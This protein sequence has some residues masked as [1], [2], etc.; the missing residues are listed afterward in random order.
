MVSVSSSLASWP[1]GPVA[2]DVGGVDYFPVVDV[3]LGEGLGWR[4]RWPVSPGVRVATAAG[5]VTVTEGVGDGHPG[6]GDVAG[7]L[8][9]EGVVDPVAGVGPAGRS[10]TLV[11]RVPVLSIGW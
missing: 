4:C 8:D 5:Q 11:S 7:V 6:E 2:V 10:T 9:L 3:G 1:W